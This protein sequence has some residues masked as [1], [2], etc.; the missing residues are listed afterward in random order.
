M[1]GVASIL[2]LLS[3]GPTTCLPVEPAISEAIE[4]GGQVALADANIAEAKANRD[5]LDSLWRPRV[6]AYA[7]SLVG[8]TAVTGARLSN[9][10]GLQVTQRVIDFGD[11]ARRKRL[12]DASLAATNADRLLAAEE[13][14]IEIGRLLAAILVSTRQVDVLE[15]TYA[16]FE[17]RLSALE[18][19]LR[20]GLATRQD[21]AALRSEIFAVRSRIEAAR[22]DGVQAET[23]LEQRFGLDASALCPLADLKIGGA[24]IATLASGSQTARETGALARL[25]AA[26]AES[27]LASSA[28]LP[29]IEV[30]GR[31]AY[32]S[33]TFD[34]GFR[35]RQQGGLSIRLPLYAG[36]ALG[37]RSRQAQARQ[38]QAQAELRLA[39]EQAEARRQLLLRRRISLG[40][41]LDLLARALEE[42]TR[43]MAT[44]EER[45]GLGA[46]TIDDL[47]EVRRRY[48]AL[49]HERNQTLG[50]RLENEIEIWMVGS[51]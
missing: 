31:S 51:A 9:Q 43:E 13:S 11:A 48:D 16:V 37:A 44:V 41:R 1:I 15:T 4:R 42:T 39:R 23:M 25:R 2:A 19:L 17:R 3:V 7:D 10:V 20:Q 18:P 47:I 28:R 49:A 5:E 46:A 8:D 33:D 6:D 32:G 34:D 14:G 36:A 24:A 45:I 29:I 21:I 50:Q 40:L 35:L 12:G 27:D 38:V 30:T 26:D 22:L